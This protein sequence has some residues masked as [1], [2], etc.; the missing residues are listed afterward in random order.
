MS[1]VTCA[2]CGSDLSA[3]VSPCPNCGLPQIM[4]AVRGGRTAP[5]ISQ[6]AKDVLAGFGVIVGGIL[7]VLLVL[8]TCVHSLSSG[9]QSG[10]GSGRA[11][12]RSDGRWSEDPAVQLEK[13]IKESNERHE[14]WRSD[15]RTGRTGNP[16]CP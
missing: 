12:R 11:Y 4:P 3:G 15:C 8:G 1:L 16:E 13:I 14:R 2:G 5:A 6:S 10:S 7:W 9:P